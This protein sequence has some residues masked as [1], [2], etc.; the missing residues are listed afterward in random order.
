MALYA[1]KKNNLEQKPSP[2][3]EKPVVSTEIGTKVI[4]DASCLADTTKAI[5]SSYEKFAGV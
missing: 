2:T 3:G 5:N 1:C 4:I